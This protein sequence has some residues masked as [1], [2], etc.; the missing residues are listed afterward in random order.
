M[1]GSSAYVLNIDDEVA[2]PCLEL[3]RRMV[4]PRS[5]SLPHVTVRYPV[6]NL[7]LSNFAEYDRTEIEILQLVSPGAFW[8]HGDDPASNHP[9]T[10]FIHC[11]SDELEALAYKPDFPDSVFHITLYDGH[12]SALSRALLDVL[13]EFVW[14]L[15]LRL[16]KGTRLTRIPIGRA[17]SSAK[18]PEGHISNR[19]IQMAE[20]LFGSYESF[21][22]IQRTTDDDRLGAV[23]LLC[24]EIHSRLSSHL[25]K[26]HSSKPA[27]RLRP[28][29]PIQG[30]LWS[31][32]RSDGALVIQDE[33]GTSAALRA[34]EKSLFI[35]PPELAR[36]LVVHSLSFHNTGKV[37]FGDPALGNAIFFAALMRTE[38]KDIA[39]AIGVEL[40]ESRA[41][42]VRARWG[43]RGL[44]VLSGNFLTA[45]LVPDRSMIVANPPYRRFQK[46]LFDETLTWRRLIEDEL[47][48]KV[49]GRSDLYVY[50][51][52]RAHSWMAPRCVSTWLLPSEFLQSQYGRAVRQYLSQHVSLRRIHL[53]DQDASR[54]ENAKVS[55]VAVVFQNSPPDPLLSTQVSVGGSI[56]QPVESRT[57]KVT[58]L[59]PANKWNFAFGLRS[60]HF[61]SV[62]RTRQVLLQEVFRIRRGIATG[63]NDLF[64]LSDARV[65]EL[66]IPRDWIKPLIPRSRYLKSNI[67]EADEQ[68]DPIV[69]PHE[70]LIDIEASAAEIRKVAPKLADYLAWVETEVGHRRLVRS[71]RPFYRQ[72]RVP[73]PPL[74]FAYMASLSSNR[75]PSRF[76]LN[77]SRGVIL[78][79]YL[80]VYPTA[81]IAEAL[82]SGELTYD[83]L[84]QVLLRVDSDELGRNGRRYVG[85]LEKLEPTELGKV[86]L[87]DAPE[88]L[89]QV[90]RK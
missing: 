12:A 73:S 2:G 63:A 64:V 32:I 10:V 23:R 78:N 8:R 52:L 59:D 51:L 42:T 90:V 70:W 75:L 45:E 27:Q 17:G 18:N 53:Y 11:E 65:S 86:A 71:R 3:I 9:R 61:A 31:D 87:A 13:N 56:L 60:N 46:L 88:E 83:A 25:S 26:K 74:F 55:S 28:Q 1:S 80:G 40:D 89:L 82:E 67:V 49:D 81:G 41:E 34:A 30:S 38:R 54:F 66:G 68:L 48:L 84:Y 19:G 37:C 22:E 44:E 14:N 6:R 57:V 4:Q 20:Q 7:S 16:P 5:R 69:D 24:G 47:D 35:T 72:E 29:L 36:E 58:K 50:F 39:S 33:A 15:D 79:N 76:F 77:R 85:G 62:R 21:V 43:N